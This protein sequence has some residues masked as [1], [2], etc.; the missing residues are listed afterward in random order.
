MIRSI[1]ERTG[2]FAPHTLGEIFVNIPFNYRHGKKVYDE[3]SQLIKKSL[4]WN[5]YDFERYIVKHFNLILQYAKSFKLYQDKY[6][7]YGVMNLKVNSLKDIEKFP[8]I[9]KDDVKKYSYEFRGRYAHETGGTSGNILKVHLDKDVWSRE[10]AY[11][12][13]IWGKLGYNYKNAQFIF[14]GINYKNEFL[15]YDFQHNGYYINIYMNPAEHLD[16]FFKTLIDKKI[17]FFRGY[18]SAILDFLRKIE[19]DITEEQRKILKKYIKYI[20]FH[21]EHVSNHLIEYIKNVWNIDFISCYGHSEVCVLAATEINNEEY[22]VYHTYGYVEVVDDKLIGT[23]YHNF[24]MPL[25]RY[26]TGDFVKPIKYENGLLK[27]FIIKEGRE[28]DFIFDKNNNPIPLTAV[29]LGRHHK[30][31]NY[32]DHIQLYQEEKGKATILI[33]AKDIY[34]LDLPKQ[35]D[36]NDVNIDFDFKFLKEPLR[37]TAGKIPIRVRSLPKLISK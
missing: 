21:S 20:V 32:I 12:H 15:K 35:M 36:L 29:L 14:K 1:I 23:S 26:N 19:N 13:H 31:F 5:E 11:Y 27:S 6:T 34:K 7:D 22:S 2:N 30:I 10:W 28:S 9:T 25:I 33:T 16:E 17:S 4:N 8:I 24:D 3:F 18:P 37:T